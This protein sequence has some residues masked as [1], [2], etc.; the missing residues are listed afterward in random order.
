[1]KIT[2]TK[3]HGLSCVTPIR[4]THTLRAMLQ[5]GDPFASDRRSQGSVWNTRNFGV[6]KVP[7]G[8]I[9]WAM[10]KT[11]LFVPPPQATDFKGTIF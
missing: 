11:A 7:K 8:G 10:A 2:G 1:M 5:R 3:V 9:C 4:Q 6:N